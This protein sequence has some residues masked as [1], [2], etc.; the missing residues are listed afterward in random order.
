MQDPRLAE[1]AAQRETSL[2]VVLPA[3]V[4]SGPLEPITA[5]LAALSGH[6]AVVDAVGRALPAVAIP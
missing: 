4:G 1:L 2:A 3:V 6:S 5:V